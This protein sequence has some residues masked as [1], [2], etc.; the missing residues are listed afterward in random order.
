MLI[1][2]DRWQPL[3]LEQGTALFEDAPFTWA[4][5]GG[6]CVEQF[7]GH[8]FREHEDIDIVVFRDQQLDL[9]TWLVDWQLYAA[10][11]PGTLRPWLAGES[12]PFGVHDIWGHRPDSAVWQLQLM[13]TESDGEQ[14][15]YRQDR[16]ICGRRDDLI[17][18]Y[19]GL[20][21]VR[22]E[23]QLFYKARG[24]RN[25]DELDFRACLPLLEPSAVQWLRQSIQHFF[26]DGHP[27]LAMLP[28]S[29]ERTY[30]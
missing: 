10:D 13:L 21:C 14:W 1:L 30:P 27:W 25:K 12:L 9:Q 3:T 2:E 16:D 20:P 6:Y 5:A 23:V 7:V 17:V 15:F 19:N 28:P 24:R 29:D 22:I 11:P 18:N 4:L 8:R 26:P